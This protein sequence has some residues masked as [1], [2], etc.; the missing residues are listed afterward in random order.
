MEK[1]IQLR[2]HN[3]DFRIERSETLDN[4]QAVIEG[5][6]VRFNEP[7]PYGLSEYSEVIAPEAFDE[8]LEEDIRCLYNHDE[9]LVLGRTRNN[10]LILEKKP[11]GIW[12]KCYINMNDTDARNAY[13]RVKRG[14]VSQ[15]SFGFVPVEESY[16]KEEKRVT[17]RKLRLYEVS[18][19]TFPFYEGTSIDAR[20][21]I[22]ELRSI[23]EKEKAFSEMKFNYL[24]RSYKWQ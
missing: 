9:K 22:E 2:N 24:R 16:D 8:T 7:A 13:E 1:K 15:C 19:C 20:S 11:E 14:D 18:L 6:F 12:A 5:F 21:K 3:T 10:T 17:V 4:S 23:E